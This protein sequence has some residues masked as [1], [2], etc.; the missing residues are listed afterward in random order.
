[1][2]PKANKPYSKKEL[3]QEVVE[4]KRKHPTNPKAASNYGVPISITGDRI[5][6]R[7]YYRSNL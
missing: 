5:I 7:F 4:V 3:T 2:N 6:E 1:M